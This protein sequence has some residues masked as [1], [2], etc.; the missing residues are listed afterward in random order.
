[1]YY[2]FNKT[3]IIK[4]FRCYEAK[5]EESEKAGSRHESNLGHLWLEPP[6]LCHWATTAR[7][8]PTLI[9]LYL[10]CT[11]RCMVLNVSVTHLAVTQYMCRQNS[12]RGW[13]E[14]SLHQERTHAEWFSHYLEPNI[15][16]T[17]YTH[18][19][20]SSFISMHAGTPPPHKM[21]YV[22]NLLF[23]LWRSHCWPTIDTQ[24]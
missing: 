7:Q 2:L 9:I 1:M 13:R 23:I 24:S 8:P 15:F 14:N 22:P 6:V 17:I 11:C 18:A 21:S 20:P 12:I 4:E 5:I 10:Y 19:G 16:S 3:K